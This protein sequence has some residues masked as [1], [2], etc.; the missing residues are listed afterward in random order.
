MPKY[1]LAV[2]AKHSTHSHAEH[3]AV[4]ANYH[5]VPKICNVYGIEYHMLTKFQTSGLHALPVLS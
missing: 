2:L 4:Y 1:V 5:N 3:Y